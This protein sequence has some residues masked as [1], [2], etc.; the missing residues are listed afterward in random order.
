[1]SINFL[2]SVTLNMEQ[3][4]EIRKHN[5]KIGIRNVWLL[6]LMILLVGVI[7]LVIIERGSIEIYLWGFALPATSLIIVGLMDCIKIRNNYKKLEKAYQ[8]IQERKK[9]MDQAF[10]QA[11]DKAYEDDPFVYVKAGTQEIWHILT[12]AFKEPDGRINVNNIL[13]WTSGLSGIACQACVWEK[14]KQTGTKA[15]FDVLEVEG[16][17][18]FY[19]GEELNKFLFESQYS[20]W[21]LASKIYSDLEPS[22]P[23]P[24]LEELIKHCVNMFGNEEYRIWGEINPYDKAI[25]YAKLWKTL[26]GKIKQLCTNSDQWPLMFGLVLQKA[27]EMAYKVIPED[28]N[29][30]EMVMENV[31]F[32]AK[33]DIKEFL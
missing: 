5:Y 12:R 2:K 18:K 6:I 3:T 8:N 19:M 17:R 16:G 20:V 7:I 11:L 10:K 14:A 23:L 30:L 33:L 15:Q 24:D 26:E 13:L 32:T 9:N 31:L 22:K 27:L 25:E 29:G 28:K 4:S 1:M 21:S